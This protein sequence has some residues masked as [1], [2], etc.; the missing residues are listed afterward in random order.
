MFTVSK[1]FIMGAAAILSASTASANDE[2]SVTFR[3]EKALSVE[4]NYKAFALTA[5]RACD[6]SGSV[7]NSF[8]A[9]KLCRTSLVADA[10][11]AT[12]VGN[13]IAYHQNRMDAVQ[14][15]SSGR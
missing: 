1:A 10:V 2:V 11:A 5:K 9:Q 15:A 13:F 7:L 4:A 3:Y 12:K 14:I 6:A 8:K